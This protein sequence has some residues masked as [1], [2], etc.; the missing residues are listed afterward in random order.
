MLHRYCGTD[1]RSHRP[2]ASPAI[3]T[4]TRQPLLKGAADECLSLEGSPMTM[5]FEGIRIVDFTQIDQGPAGSS[6]T[7]VSLPSNRPNLSSEDAKEG[8]R[9]FAEKRKSVLRGR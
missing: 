6:R 7:R 4:S 5:A 8:R 3:A 1:P 2:Q 9:S